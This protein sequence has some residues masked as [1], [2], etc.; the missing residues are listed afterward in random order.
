MLNGN[1]ATFTGTAGLYEAWTAEH[2]D[3]YRLPEVFMSF[4]LGLFLQKRSP[5]YDIFSKE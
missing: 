5:Y 1:Y 3:V 2:C 4:P